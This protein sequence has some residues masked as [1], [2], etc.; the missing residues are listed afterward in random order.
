MET[1]ETMEK[2]KNVRIKLIFGIGKFFDT[3]NPNNYCFNLAK[4]LHTDQTK[5]LDFK[6]TKHFCILFNIDGQISI[7]DEN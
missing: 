5:C 3:R 1:M 4:I 6:N 2:I 7:R